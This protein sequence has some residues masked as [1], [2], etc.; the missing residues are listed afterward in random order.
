MNKTENDD[1]M[2][3]IRAFHKHPIP[4]YGEMCDVITPNFV[5]VSVMILKYYLCYAFGV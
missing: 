5:D 4:E 2:P 1:I 3:L